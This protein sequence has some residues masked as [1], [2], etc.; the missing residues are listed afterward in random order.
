MYRN[1]KLSNLHKHKKATLHNRKTNKENLLKLDSVKS[2][3][4]VWSNVRLEFPEEKEVRALC[5][6]VYQRH[7]DESVH[8]NSTNPWHLLLWK[9]QFTFWP[10]PTKKSHSH[11][12]LHC[13]GTS[14]KIT[15]NFNLAK[16][17]ELYPF[18]S[19]KD[20]NRTLAWLAKTIGS[21]QYMYHRKVFILSLTSFWL[22]FTCELI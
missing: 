19:L 20:K 14:S 5:S 9:R 18:I 1:L 15:V 16:R 21:L 17:F 2:R 8:N 10:F 22:I 6:L 11:F 7:G 3:D 4:G 13:T 12:K